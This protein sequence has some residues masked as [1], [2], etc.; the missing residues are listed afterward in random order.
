MPATKHDIGSTRA[1]QSAN[2]PTEYVKSLPIYEDLMEYRYPGDNISMHDMLIPYH[3]RRILSSLITGRSADPTPIHKAGSAEYDLFV[4]NVVTAL[5]KDDA[6]QPTFDELSGCTGSN[7]VPSD[8]TP[9]LTD[10][11]TFMNPQGYDESSNIALRKEKGLLLVS[12]RCKAVAKIVLRVLLNRAINVPLRYKHGSS[13][14]APTME[15]SKERKRTLI[16][17]TL[18]NESA[19]AQLLFKG[20]AHELTRK[21]MTA[22]VIV[23]GYRSQHEKPDKKRVVKGPLLA[24]GVDDTRYPAYA[25][26]THSPRP[27]FHAARLRI[28]RG[29]PL[30]FNITC[31]KYIL[32]FAEYM[33][34]KFAAT[35]KNSIPSANAHAL[36]A[37]WGMFADPVLA[38]GDMVTYDATFPEEMHRLIEE[39]FAE[40]VSTE[41][42]EYL[43]ATRSLPSY[44]ASS[45]KDFELY[46]ITGFLS[47]SVVELKPRAALVSGHIATSLYGKIGTVVNHFCILDKLGSHVTESFVEAVLDHD[48]RVASSAIFM[49]NGGD[50]HLLVG[51]KKMM[52]RYFDAAK[53]PDLFFAVEPERNSVYLGTVYVR[54]NG[55]FVPYPNIV[56]FV[57]KLLAP[58]RAWNHS[59]KT[60]WQIGLKARLLHYATAPT[61]SRVIDIID[62]EHSAIYG[63]PYTAYVNSLEGNMADVDALFLSDP[64]IIHYK[65]EPS[66]ISKEVYDL[67]YENVPV[68]AIKRHWP[69][70][71]ELFID[72]DAVVELKHRYTKRY[73]QAW[74]IHASKLTFME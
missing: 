38:A 57:T 1:K 71:D 31:A 44:Q 53:S 48:Q 64:D 32:P 25:D 60:Y 66:D 33:S 18:N 50:D 13:A 5:S 46:G 55:K 15:R 52:A 36:D 45:P 34:V 54:E 6:L 14:G 74:D 59:S 28:V 10:M 26:K 61:F 47:G 63:Y 70:R 51:D 39:R 7:A 40:L 62:R 56:T 35:F 30:G 22:P 23:A 21:Y 67:I 37:L 4:K 58:E 2:E 73:N 41:F 19:I 29:V 43:R 9:A 20:K 68:E 17:L 3:A 27:G 12:D 49:R 16:A 65:L 24:Y 8:F 72:D 42:S 11:T 69:I